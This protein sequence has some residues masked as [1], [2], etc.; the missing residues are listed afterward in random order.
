[1]KSMKGVGPWAPP[2]IRGRGAR[3]PLAPPRS[4][5]MGPAIAGPAGPGYAYSFTESD[6]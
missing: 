1:M 5:P 2:N 3:A 6:Y 4:P